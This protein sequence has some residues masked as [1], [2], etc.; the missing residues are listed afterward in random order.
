[1]RSSSL[2]HDKHRTISY[3][4]VFIFS[5]HYKLRQVESIRIYDTRSFPIDYIF[6]T[7]HLNI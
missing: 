1:M 7:V 4:K 2:M 6:V 3:F 5:Y